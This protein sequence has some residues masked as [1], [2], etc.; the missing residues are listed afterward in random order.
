M[1][2]RQITAQSVEGDLFVVCVSGGRLKRI[3]M[4]DPA[5][6]HHT[7]DSIVQMRH[8]QI[9]ACEFVAEETVVVSVANQNEIRV[10][11]AVVAVSAATATA[12]AAASTR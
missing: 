5:V 10:V 2:L 4:E 7:T 12:A 1:R 8:T 9:D 3:L 6:I 11:A